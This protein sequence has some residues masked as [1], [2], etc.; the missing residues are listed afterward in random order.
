MKTSLAS[1]SLLGATAMMLPLMA[2][3]ESNTI[4]GTGTLSTTAHVDFTVVIPKMLY[5]RIGSGSTYSTGTLAAQGPIDLITFSPTMAQIGTGAA[6]TGT[7]G[8]LATG[9][10]TAAIVSN[11]S[12]VTLAATATGA[13]TDANGDTIPFTQISTAAATLTA[14]NTLL[15]APALTNGASS[16]TVTLTAAANK[17]VTA[18]AKW[19]FTYLNSA[20]VPGGTYG[21][22]N[23][24]N[25]RVTYTATAP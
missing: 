9:A 12:S 5:L 15:N 6:I 4:S 3:A 21:G 17:T 2:F 20:T 24:Q 18:D 7:G 14:G 13:L 23:T 10:E 25:G 16:T 22:V 11:S 1:K 8:D 19:T